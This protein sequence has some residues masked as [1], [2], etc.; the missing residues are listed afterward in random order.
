[1]KICAWLV[2]VGLLVA[3]TS[4]N[5]GIGLGP[6]DGGAGGPD[7]G[8]VIDPLDAPP[9]CTSNRMWTQGS[10]GSSLM[11]PG[12]ACIACHSTSRGAPALTLAGTVYPSGHEPDDCNGSSG[13]NG[14]KVVITDANGKVTTLTPNSAGNFYSQ[15]AVAAPYQAKVTLNGMERAMLADQMTGDC[16]SC[17]TQTGAEG[18]PGRITLP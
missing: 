2:P 7:G 17:H 5:P 8:S 14:A 13:V 6:D 4:S 11:Y 12:Q 9:T 3:C 18:A 15:V 16:N 1:M 10:R